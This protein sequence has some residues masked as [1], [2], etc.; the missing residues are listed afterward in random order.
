LVKRKVKLLKRLWRGCGKTFILEG[1]VALPSREGNFV[2]GCRSSYS[3]PCYECLSTSKFS[4]LRAQ[5]DDAKFLLG[6]HGEIVKNPLV[7][8]GEAREV[9]SYGGV[10]DLE[11]LGFSIKPY[12]PNKGGGSLTKLLQL[13]PGF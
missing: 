2:E 9:K 12:L 3:H 11:I 13:L 8:L 6:S 10:L 7:Q 1:K 4:L 5:P